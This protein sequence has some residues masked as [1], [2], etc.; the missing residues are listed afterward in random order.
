[1]ANI[2]IINI[3]STS[4]RAGMFMDND[5]VFTETINHSPGKTAELKTF[6]DWYKFNLNVIDDIL[7]RYQ[8]R[9][10]NLDLVVSRGGLTHPIKTGAYLINQSMIV[11]L[12]SGRYGWHPCN[13][14]PVI[15]KKIADS[16]KTKAIIFDSPMSDE[17]LPIAKFSG[18]KGVERCAAFHVLSHKAAAKR[19]A[20]KLNISYNKSSFIVV[21]MGG[22]IT[23]CAHQNGRMIDGTHGINEGPFTPQRAGTLPLQKIIQLSFSGRYSQEELNQKLFGSGGVASYL[24]TH[25]IKQLEEKISKGDTKIRQVLEAMGYQISKEIGSMAV[26]LSGHIDAIAITGSLSHAKTIMEE[27]Q[28]RISFLAR[29]LI[30]PDEDELVTLAAGGISVLNRNE[31]IQIYRKE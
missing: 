16:Y 11:D 20:A 4:T 28:N 30:L 24:G 22:G 21:H 7:N 8:A 6:K 3:G 2:F 31:E 23:I 12:T 25:D 29:V 27:I 17:M 14:G 26:V 19:A 5:P 1:M 10:T 15:A 18:L 9:I 13:T